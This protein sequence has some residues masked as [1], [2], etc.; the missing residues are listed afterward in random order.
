MSSAKKWEHVSPARNGASNVDHWGVQKNKKCKIQSTGFLMLMDKQTWIRIWILLQNLAQASHVHA[1]IAFGVNSTVVMWGMF[2]Q[3]TSGP[4]IPTKEGLNRMA[5]MNIVANPVYS[6]FATVYSHLDW[7]LWHDN[8]PWNKTCIVTK[9]PQKRFPA[10]A[11]LTHS[12]Q[13]DN[14][15]QHLWDD[16]ERSIST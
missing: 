11:S 9:W 15:F 8:T 4:L 16:V 3:H 5:Y 6:F 10:E 12:P 13:D 1:V 2:S 7:P 14:P